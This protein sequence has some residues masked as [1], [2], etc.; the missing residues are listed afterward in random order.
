[1]RRLAVVDRLLLGGCVVAWL[2][3]VGIAVVAT[4][5]LVD[6]GSAS[7][8]NELDNQASTALYVVIVV[9]AVIILAAVPLLISARRA[10]RAP[11]RKQALSSATAVTPAHIAQSA[12]VG[13]SPAERLRVFG[14]VGDQV[15]TRPRLPRPTPRP[16][17]PGSVT[18]ADV[19]RVWL[20]GTTAVAGTLGVATAGIAG[21][22]Y[23]LGAGDRGLA[24]AALG[25]AGVAT[26]AM[27]VVP[28]LQ[29]RYLSERA[30]TRPA[31]IVR[32]R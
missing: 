9:S 30:S 12:S 4:L 28:W 2:A 31:P 15:E 8:G 5:A 21:M 20:R 27:P 26:L 29:L 6:L 14:S 25:L 23:Y 1:M 17:Y 32:R 7:H 18:T 13:Q 16:R 22:A 3:A 24:W 19:D 10:A 11:V